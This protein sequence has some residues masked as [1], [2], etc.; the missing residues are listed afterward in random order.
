MTALWFTLT[1][2]VEPACALTLSLDMFVVVLVL[3]MLP[4]QCSA[5]CFDSL[6]GCKPPVL[7]GGILVQTKST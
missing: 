7:Y 1:Y 5:S 6:V 3:C 4:Q 2:L